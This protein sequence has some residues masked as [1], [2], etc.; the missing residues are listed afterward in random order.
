[1]SDLT[2]IPSKFMDVVPSD[3][4]AINTDLGLYCGGAGVVKVVGRNSVTATFT[5]QAGQHLSGKFNLVL[6]TGTTATG[7]VALYA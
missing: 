7:L 5:V 1:M 2:L 4:N 6:A 3:S